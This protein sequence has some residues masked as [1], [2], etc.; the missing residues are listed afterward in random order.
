MRCDSTSSQR[1]KQVRGCRVV[2]PH[3][4]YTCVVVVCT[5]P[6]SSAGGS[7]RR[8]GEICCLR[9]C[10]GCATPKPMAFHR[11]PLSYFLSRWY[12]SPALPSALV[13]C[14]LPASGAAGLGFSRSFCSLPRCVPWFVILR[15][16]CGRAG[17]GFGRCDVVFGFRPSPSHS[18][19]GGMFTMSLF[20]MRPGSQA[21][22]SQCVRQRTSFGVALAGWGSECGPPMRVTVH[23]RPKPQTQTPSLCFVCGHTRFCGSLWPQTTAISTGAVPFALS[24]PATSSDASLF[25]HC[26]SSVLDSRIFA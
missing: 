8:C 4:R 19:L 3:F 14:G 15:H 26:A 18:R 21:G 2:F 7:A 10:D 13:R 20:A 23:L 17:L 25:L 9:W 1:R 11:H 22:P 16:R 6:H 12:A 5:A 24:A